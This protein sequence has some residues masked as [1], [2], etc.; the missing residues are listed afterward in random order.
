MRII[1]VDFLTGIWVEIS[2]EPW[3]SPL[4]PSKAMTYMYKLFKNKLTV[5]QMRSMLKDAESPYARS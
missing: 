1:L 4:R 2:T 5:N 3:E